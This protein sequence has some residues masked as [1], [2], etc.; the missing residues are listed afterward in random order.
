MAALRNLVI[1]ALR[2]TGHTNVAVALRH[3]VR[4]PQRPSPPTR[5]HNDFVSA[6]VGRAVGC[7]ACDMESVDS[8]TEK[9]ASNGAATASALRAAHRRI[10]DY[11]ARPQCGNFP[12]NLCHIDEKKSVMIVG[13]SH[14]T[15]TTVERY[16]RFLHGHIG[17]LTVIFLRCN[18]AVRH[19]R[20][21]ELNRPLVGG[22]VI[23]SPDVKGDVKGGG[24][25]CITG[26][27]DGTS[28]FVTAGHVVNAVHAEC[29]QPRKSDVNDWLVGNVVV[30]SDYK[31]NAQSDS[32]FL[33]SNVEL[34]DHRIW[35]SAA[36]VYTVTGAAAVPALGT[37][38]FMQGASM[39]RE[40]AGQIAATNVTV[41]FGDGGVLQAQCLANY[42]SRIGDSGAP[43]YLKDVDPNIRLVGLNVG[44]TEVRHTEP[45]PD[46]HRYPP[47]R[48]NLYGIVSPWA[49]VVADLGIA[50]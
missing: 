17:D 49:N 9:I 23:T 12:I 50:H 15:S 18:P 14:P 30:V 27:R 16:R 39:T 41:T 22:I 35:K 38:V 25:I 33:V 37:Q 34:G 2:L 8:F 44:A 6:L 47:A 7:L 48:N 43:V 36:S 4:H 42:D 29:Y 40:R 11:M 26:T 31:G 21:N 3:H 45:V 13:I 20:K 46:Q 28:G 5:S 10:S 24:T 32:A 1:T 19:A